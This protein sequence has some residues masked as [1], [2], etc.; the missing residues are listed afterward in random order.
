MLDICK[1]LKAEYAY[2]R[3]ESKTPENM[4]FGQLQVDISKPM[5]LHDMLN[6]FVV[7]IAETDIVD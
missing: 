5:T 4:C 1:V 6:T 2:V 3:V 7:K